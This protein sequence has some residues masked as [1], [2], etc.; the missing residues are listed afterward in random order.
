MFYDGIPPVLL[1]RTHNVEML[2]RKEMEFEAVV[3]IMA[4]KFRWEDRKLAD[5]E[6]YEEK[7]TWEREEDETTEAES[8]STFNP[9]DKAFTMARNRYTD[10]RE[11]KNV[12][13]PR[14]MRP[15]QEAILE[16]RMEGYRKTLKDYKTKNLSRKKD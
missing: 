12:Y 2:C 6:L 3:G 7:S 16:R 11:N 13:L 5:G 4:C 10:L 14:E 8:R 1:F 9:I 15:K